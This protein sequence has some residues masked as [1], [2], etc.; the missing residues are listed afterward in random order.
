M[1]SKAFWGFWQNNLNYQVKVIT[2][3]SNKAEMSHISACYE[4]ELTGGCWRR[5]A[6][7]SRETVRARMRDRERWRNGEIERVWASKVYCVLRL[8]NVRFAYRNLN[9]WRSTG[10]CN[11]GM[12]GRSWSDFKSKSNS[13]ISYFGD[14]IGPGWGRRRWRDASPHPRLCN[15]VCSTQTRACWENHSSARNNAGFQRHKLIR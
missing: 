14:K 12:F 3:L 9:R 15:L 8:T 5:G 1:K 11:K 4:A 6:N 10:L 13:I 7:S 2:Q